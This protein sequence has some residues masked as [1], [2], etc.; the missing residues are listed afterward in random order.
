MHGIKT[1]LL[2]HECLSKTNTRI[3]K[4]S[5]VKKIFWNGFPLHTL[6][7]VYPADDNMAVELRKPTDCS[8]LKHFIF[9]ARVFMD[10]LTI[11]RINVEYF[12]K[13]R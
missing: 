8:T 2:E 10:L 5:T 3:F 7:S 11:R 13:Q 1:Y 6:V 4:P 9:V 12:I